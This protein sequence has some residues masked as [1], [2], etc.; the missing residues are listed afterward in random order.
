MCGVVCVVCG[1]AVVVCAVR[2]VCLWLR[3]GLVR[4]VVCVVCCVVMG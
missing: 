2:D 1:A 4:D 3:V